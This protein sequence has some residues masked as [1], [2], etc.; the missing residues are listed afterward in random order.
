[1][2]RRRTIGLAL[3]AVVVS[4]GA[5]MAVLARSRLSGIAETGPVVPTA[6]VARQTLELTVHLQGDMR[7]LRQQ[8][9][10]APSVGGALR[11]LHL[12]DSG[13]TVKE[14][15]ILLEFDPADQVHALE[16]AQSEVLE[17]E[18]EIIKRRADTEAQTAQDKVALLTAQSEVRRAE[19]DASV[20]QDL[21]AANE[22]KIRQAALEEA[23][24]ALART[25]QDIKARVAVNSAGLSVLE[26]RRT[27]ANMS[28]DRAR[29]NIQDLVIRSPMAGVLSVR[30]NRDAGGMFSYYMTLA[31]YRIGDTVNPGRQVVDV[32]DVSRMEIRAMVNEQ[33]RANLEE[34]QAV[35]VTSTAV[36]GEELT[37]K[38][39][40]VSGSG[41]SERRAGP[42]RLFEVTLTL[43]RPNPALLPGTSVEVVA[44]GRTVENALVL[45]RQT[46]FE[47]DGRPIVYE[48]VGAGF[49]PRPVKVLH[50]TESRVAV[51]G[52]SEGAE[53]ALVNPDAAA[54][55]TSGPSKPPA[56]PP[57][58]GPQ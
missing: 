8:T 9:I 31:P 57:A 17:A 27:K 34:G 54:S 33:D 3:V 26:E 32:F 50:R 58:Q 21:I 13:A 47:K 24:R 46:I 7:A 5:A 28:A 10:L 30:E 11:I 37:A 16:Q 20:D 49:E 25:E 41:R 51:E 4:A 56:P 15:E 43:D 48:R 39:T 12:A 19:L 52:L 29:Q 18:Q 23:R 35:I 22:Y 1:V 14:G 6:R 2:T 38:V 40:A 44:S 45:P 53:I 42:L 55:T 36:P